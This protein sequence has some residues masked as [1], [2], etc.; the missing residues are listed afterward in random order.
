MFIANLAFTADQ[1]LL[2]SMG[3]GQTYWFKAFVI[4]LVTPMWDV[5]SMTSQPLILSQGYILS[6]KNPDLE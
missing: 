6:I 1:A 4:M 3:I 2:A 5:D